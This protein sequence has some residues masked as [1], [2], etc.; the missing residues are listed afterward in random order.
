MR[1]PGWQSGECAT[2]AL[3]WGQRTKGWQPVWRRPTPEL[4][5]RRGSDSRSQRAAS[6]AQRLRHDKSFR[7]LTQRR[8]R[9]ILGIGSRRMRIPLLPHQSPRSPKRR[10]PKYRR[11][12]TEKSHRPKREPLVMPDY[13][14]YVVGAFEFRMVSKTVSVRLL[15]LSDSNV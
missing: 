15:W 7:T 1:V 8:R 14:K 11:G 2:A 13:I 5:I 10:T 12:G 3:A 6:H 9:R 4:R